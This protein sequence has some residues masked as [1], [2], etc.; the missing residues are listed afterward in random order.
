MFAV[1]WSQGIEDAWSDLASFI[2]K[3]IAALVVL[4][5]GWFIA[6]VIRKVIVRVLDKIKFDQL[7]DK[8]GIGGPVERAGYPDSGKLLAQLLYYGL[9]LLVIQL[10]ISVFGDSAVNEAFDSL[11]AFIPKLFIALIIVVITG[12]VANAVKSL[13]ASATAH[14]DAGEFISKA[15]FA[16]VW[17][18][19]GFA[20]FDQLDVASDTVDTLFETLAYS[21]GLIVVIKFGVGGIWAAR[22]R[23]WPAVYDGIA[24]AADSTGSNDGVAAAAGTTTASDSD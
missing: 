9:M 11:L 12:V 18:I 7:V 19:G 1:E 4:V 15:A 5:I 21:L 3:L 8:A 22:D 2:P 13:V 24:G 14:L 16:A 17:V 20:A 6:R 23:F 10:A